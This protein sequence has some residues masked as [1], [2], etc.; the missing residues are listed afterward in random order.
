[1]KAIT[2]LGA[3]ALALALTVACTVQAQDSEDDPVQITAD[4]T[5][6]VVTGTFYENALTLAEQCGWS[7]QVFLQS[8]NQTPYMRHRHYDRRTYVIEFNGMT[9]TKHTE[10]PYYRLSGIP[11]APDSYEVQLQGK[12]VEDGS[13]SSRAISAWHP[14]TIS[15]TGEHQPNIGTRTAEATAVRDELS[16]VTS[17]FATLSESVETVVPQ[18]ATLTARHC[19]DLEDHDC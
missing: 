1:M 15:A 18:V 6:N 4:R 10:R 9:L 13:D 19:T 3:V 16:T 8:E 17:Q 12:C 5:A 14:F 2:I 11:Q 7:N